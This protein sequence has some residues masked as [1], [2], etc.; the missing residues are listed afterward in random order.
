MKIRLK[1]LIKRYGDGD[2]ALEVLS[3]VNYEFPEEGMIG[4]V[5]RSGVGKSTLLQLLGGLDRPSEGEILFGETSLG[6]LSEDA[7]SS[8]RGSNIGFVFQFHHLLPE[9]TALENVALPLIIQGTEDEAA[10]REA[11]RVLERV[12]LS[13]RGEHRPHALSGGEQQRVAIARAIISKP[14]VVLLDEPT[15]NLDIDNAQMVQ[16]LLR[17]LQRELKNLMIVVTHSLEL[18]SGLDLVLVMQP[19][20][21]LSP[22]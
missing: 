2:H 15:G 19:G 5:G 11:S 9:F 16:G 20:G 8:F 6:A 17:E 1:E 22:R 4:V 3:R 18:A 14:K 12:G 21:A 7:L 10:L 13:H